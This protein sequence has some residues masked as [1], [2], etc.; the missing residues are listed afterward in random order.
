MLALG[1]YIFGLM[2]CYVSFGTLCIPADN[3]VKD[4]EQLLEESAEVAA[5][6][7]K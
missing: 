6:A 3:G 5:E 1:S 4:A 7:E 2:T